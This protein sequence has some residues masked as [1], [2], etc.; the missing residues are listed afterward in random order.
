MND[1]D[2]RIVSMEFDNKKFETNIQTTIK[3]LKN[4][5]ESLLLKNASKGFSEV[6]KS[7][8][9]VSLAPLSDAIDKINHR[10][11]TLGIVGDQVIRNLV[12]FTT[13]AGKEMVSAFTIDPVKTGF[14]EYETQI[15]SVQTILANT[16]KEGASIDQVNAALNELN[17]YADMTI[18]NF[19]EMT[20]N[21]GR[22]TAAGV[23]LDT[24]VSA[25]KGI[26]NL[27]AVSGS[28]SQQTS[29]A[30]YQLSQ[31]L[32]SGTVKLMDW[33][34]VVNANMGGQVF[35]DAL[36]E[37]ARVH[38]IQIDAMI[39]K[40]GSFRESLKNGWLTT[41]VLTETLEK[42]TV[43]TEGLTEAQVDQMRA[44]WKARGYTE[45]QIDAIIE[46][47]K[48]ATDAATKVK[49]FTQLFDTLK[50]ASQSGWTQ[51]WQYIIGDFEE[52]KE[53]LTSISDEFQSIINASAD[54]R[55]S[56]LKF[57]HDNGGREKFIKSLQ[58]IYSIIKGI[59]SIANNVFRTIF[60]PMTAERLLD[61]TDKL[62]NFTEKI[63]NSLGFVNQFSEAISDTAE[64]AA[65][66][67]DKAVGDIKES[68]DSGAEKNEERALELYNNMPQWMKLWVDRT[69]S[70]DLKRISNWRKSNR[71]AWFDYWEAVTGQDMSAQRQAMDIYSEMPE[72]MRNWVDKSESRDLDRIA[73]W[74]AEN[75]A[76]W[77]SYWDA[78][79]SG[80]KEAKEA[81]EE[82]NKEV[83]KTSDVV[84]TSSESIT[85][86]ARKLS[87]LEK[88]MTAAGV[89]AKILKEAFIA[90]GS[91]AIKIGVSTFTPLIKVVGTAAESLF[92]LV[93]AF[94]ET[95]DASEFFQ[96]SMDKI[97]TAVSPLGQILA[98]V[99]TKII[100]FAK[101]LFFEGGLKDVPST[102]F[103]VAITG[104]V[105]LVDAIVSLNSKISAYVSSSEIIQNGISEVTRVIS[106]IPSY[107]S[108]AV[109]AVSEFAS[110]VK[111]Y[112]EES[113][114]LSKW[115]DKIKTKFEGFLTKIGEFYNKVKTFF[116]ESKGLKTGSIK[117]FAKNFLKDLKPLEK[118]NQFF[119]DF[120]TW[121]GKS[122]DELKTK[123]S[124]NSTKYGD[125]I[126]AGLTW[127]G[128]K[129]KKAIETITDISIKDL[130][131]TIQSIYATFAILQMIRGFGKL[132]SSPAKFL[133][134]LGEAIGDFADSLKKKETGLGTT[135]LKIA[136]GV[137]ILVG[138]LFVLSKMDKASFE[139][140]M[141]ALTGIAIG[142][143]VFITSMAKIS[144]DGKGIKSVGDGL[145]RISVSTLLLIHAAKTLTKMD[146]ATMGKGFVGL[147]G[148]LGVL[149]SFMNKTKGSKLAGSIGAFIGMALAVNM[150]V[151]VIKKLG[152]MD[153][154]TVVAGVVSLKLLL[155]S[156]TSFV[157]SASRVK[158]GSMAGIIALAAG[159][160]LMIHNMNLIA[161]MDLWSIIKSIGA[162]HLVVGSINKL[163]KV[164][165]GS[166]KL[167]STIVT[168][169]GMAIALHAFVKAM[170]SLEGISGTHMIAVSTSF[171]EVFLSFG[172][173]MK[174]LSGMSIAG[175]IKALGSVAILIAGLA[176]IGIAMGTFLSNDWVLEK[177]E[178]AKDFAASLGEMIG[179]F[180]KGISDA[181]SSDAP[182]GNSLAQK[183]T[184][185]V[186]E[187]DPFFE[188]VKTIDD[189]VL[190]GITNLTSG[191]ISITGSGFVEGIASAATT[192]LTGK[193]ATENFIESLSSLASGAVTFQ[194]KS[195]SINPEIIQ[196]GIDGLSK[197]VTFVNSLPDYSFIDKVT[198]FTDVSTFA[199]DLVD[200]APAISRYSITARHLDS[201]AITK[202]AKSIGALADV[203]K[204]VPEVGIAEKILGLSN[205]KTFTENLSGLGT[206]LKRYANSVRRVNAESVT[207][208]ATAISSLVDIANAVPEVSFFDKVFGVS[209]LSTF[210]Q[211]LAKLGPNLITYANSVGSFTDDQVSNV[212]RSASMIGAIVDVAAKIPQE[213]FFTKLFNVTDMGTFASNLGTFGESIGTYVSNVRGITEDDVTSTENAA[214]VIN[215]FIESTKGN[216]KQGGIFSAFA[217]FFTGSDDI[218]QYSS[219]LA[220]FAEDMGKFAS[221]FGTGATNNI[222]DAV[223]TA[224]GVI[225][226]I[227]TMLSGSGDEDSGKS[228]MDYSSF[229]S[230]LDG[231]TL[232]INT[233]LTGFFDSGASIVTSFDNG[234]KSESNTP[235]NSATNIVSIC[236]SALNRYP[237]FYN[238]GRFMMDGFANGIRDNASSAI[239]AASNAASRALSAANSRLGIHSPSTEFA[240]TGRYSVM[241]LAEG[242][243]K[244]VGIAIDAGQSVGD[245]MLD[246]V[247]YSMDLIRT[248]LNSDMDIQPT[249]RPVIDTSNMASGIGA[250]NSYFASSRGISMPNTNFGSISAN[251]A[252]AITSQTNQNGSVMNSKEIVQAIN[253]IEARIDALSNSMAQMKVVLDSG[254]MVGQMLPQI[255][256]QL[257]LKA[258][259]NER[260]I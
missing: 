24:S 250:I 243:E 106:N 150:L 223:D 214:K 58:N 2:N 178:K 164:V 260:G 234:I 120:S 184:D 191:M 144:K 229:S 28:T 119:T 4:L 57:W 81:T 146:W 92:D 104:I 108:K 253:S 201:E 116:K 226:K 93:I 149:S 216:E 16:K 111:E 14:Q 80:A 232:T 169:G 44:M 12:N 183:L 82:V 174:I 103:S 17:H 67:V 240:K 195:G 211:D 91:G 109:K 228:M 90:F 258:M 35:Q 34:S 196:N 210:A 5:D 170:K 154:L 20:R 166:A 179:S 65:E 140:A 62:Y 199:Q 237:Q 239:S 231:I 188:K 163:S 134:N 130:F 25:I 77:N 217:D 52:A 30:M 220:T 123:V 148:L 9:K 11:S 32:A 107:A 187:L 246:A 233:S 96:S 33:N 38:G 41:E 160:R 128:E 215:A 43:T 208:S 244:N 15:N 117:E 86:N 55:N 168:V 122:T 118:I 252:R 147:F 257:G 185:F 74:Q 76:I 135:V 112:V 70:A 221:Y 206:A 126:V 193:T 230:I 248:I 68:I 157:K 26:A 212:T 95:F 13:R 136:A 177:M 202:S 49:T 172:A 115:T 224:S 19:T 200:L 98:N 3:S 125:K 71:D 7:A 222:S 192:L 132:M 47:G 186:T 158:F 155:T 207:N 245:K 89:A 175:S 171:A 21:I 241:G 37:T 156:L 102:I 197:I 53:F 143:G 51:S 180:T 110:G 39:T 242:F 129:I 94:G 99:G 227:K 61:I 247:Q 73:N 40:E 139:N 56:V 113:E 1:V 54:A 78:I 225:D 138:A 18:Y 176:A 97:V 101:Y 29:T 137:A 153:A 194:T 204:E 133:D 167:G 105:M 83:E 127:F 84:N 203:A 69:G 87:F 151:G 59:G 45:D 42:F 205:L 22:F 60:P 198:G 141:V 209:D 36:M 165:T 63:R 121:F 23:D 189:S 85:E 131:K 64:K 251:N 27:A 182:E 6:E 46:M 236:A 48:T 249:I 162:I 8:S 66:V 255:D 114:I 238:T 181:N 159:L 124:E 145:I 173:S 219:K 190:Q 10:F 256:Y 254:A 88:M 72:W 79:E 75:Q 161:D 152:K 50:E 213:G 100:Q 218:T 142:L 235:I 31:A 259:Y